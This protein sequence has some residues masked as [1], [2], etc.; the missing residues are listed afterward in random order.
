ML[1]MAHGQALVKLRVR[2]R[3]HLRAHLRNKGKGAVCHAQRLQQ[4]RIKVAFIG[5][6]R[7]F[8]DHHAQQ[9]IAHV[10][11]RIAAA[12]PGAH[13]QQIAAAVEGGRQRRIRRRVQAERLPEAH[14]IE[15][16]GMRQQVADAHGVAGLPRVFQRQVRQHLLQRRVERE[17]VFADQAQDAQRQRH[18]AHGTHL[19]ARIGLHGYLLGD[20]AQACRPHAHC[21]IGQD[22]APDGARQA[23]VLQAGGKLRRQGGTGGMGHRG[24]QQQGRHRA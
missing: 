10:R 18:L 7:D 9:A 22:F 4:L 20:I 14:V 8:L 11:I 17:P 15:A 24:A 16:G 6:A 5:L 13:A 1:E 12:G 2:L 19:H 23:F 3:A 21:A